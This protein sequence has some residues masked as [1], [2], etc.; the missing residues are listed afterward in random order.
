MFVE[1]VL[2]FELGEQFVLLDEPEAFLL[3]LDD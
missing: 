3:L 2:L 1:L